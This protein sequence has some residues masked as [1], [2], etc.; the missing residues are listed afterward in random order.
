MM[1]SLD[2][3]T[4]LIWAALICT[5]ATPVIL[6]GLLLKDFISKQIW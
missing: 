2:A 5:I 4:V 1:L 3:M 6:L